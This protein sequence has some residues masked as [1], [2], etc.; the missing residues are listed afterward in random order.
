M[1]LECKYNSFG[2]F[3]NRFRIGPAKWKYFDLIFVHD[4]HIVLWPDDEKR[5]ELRTGQSIIIY[6]QTE[7]SG[8]SIA[9][10]TRVSV[11]HFTIVDLKGLPAEI[12]ELAGHENGCE[13]FLNIPDSQT[14]RDIERLVNLRQSAGQNKLNDEMMSSVMLLVLL[15][16][17]KARDVRQAGFD[18]AFEELISFMEQNVDKNISLEEMANAYGLSASHFRM[19]F[20]KRF[21]QSPGS[22]FRKLRMAAAA[23]KLQETVIPVKEIARQTGF[24]TLPNFYRAFRA[25]YKISPVE[26]RR[27]N[28][29]KG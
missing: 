9:E 8:Y 7:F 26:Y 14:E 15:G 29:P 28:I 11:Q 10:S 18:N 27:K 20:R 2:I 25:V 4:G 13:Y 17:Y 16:I 22:F 3:N 1:L 21:F 12:A 24:D 6:P 5:L 23:K 19:L